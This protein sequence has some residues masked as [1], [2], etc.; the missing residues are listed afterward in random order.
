V[1]LALEL[2]AQEREI[3]AQIQADQEV[4]MLAQHIQAV[5]PTI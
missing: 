5:I 2:A 4:E 3:E 1:T